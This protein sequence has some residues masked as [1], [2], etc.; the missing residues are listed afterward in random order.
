MKMDQAFKKIAQRY[1]SLEAG[2]KNLQDIGTSAAR[3]SKQAI[4]A[5][6]RGDMAQ[7]AQHLRE[8][9]THL[10]KGLQLVTK[11]SRLSDGGVW[12]AAM[13]EFCE[14]SLLEKAL[15]KKDLFP[16]QSITEDP[17]ILIGGI[18]DLAG[19]LVRLAVRAATDGDKK[20]VKELAD[21]AET[22]V[23]F[24]TSLDLT[25]SLRAKGDQARQ[26]LRRLEDIRYD[27]SHRS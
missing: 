25:G 9:E 18:S 26:H 17:D 8:A 5:L 22:L 23:T 27:L 3:L 21:L 15:Q 1:Q 13:E 12:R 7:G 14:A 6:Q 10:K 2:R 16:S 20:R 19:E 24:L 4:F 11:E